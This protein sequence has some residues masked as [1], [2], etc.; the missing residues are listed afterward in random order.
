MEFGH[1][2]S[3]TVEA[4]RG[5]FRLAALEGRISFDSIAMNRR[6]HPETWILRGSYS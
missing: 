6:V 4:L 5:G 1:E 2:S 3:S